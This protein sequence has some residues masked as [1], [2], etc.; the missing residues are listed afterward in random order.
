MKMP[1]KCPEK[2]REA[3]KKA[4]KKYRE[5]NREKI[6][7]V[8]LGRYHKLY[9]NSEETKEYRREYLKKY[10]E[11]NREKIREYFANN[12]S[13]K[14]KARIRASQWQ[15][16]NVGRTRAK[17]SL[18]KKKVKQATP[19]W[20]NR[21]DLGE[22]YEEAYRMELQ[23]GIKHHV[24]H[25]IPLVHPDVCGLHIPSN[26]QVLPALENLKKGNRF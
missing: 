13:I 14:E 23:T 26:L 10:R 24:D 21:R 7:I 3:S 1:Y 9:K 8:A 19:L 15:R 16:D 17:N 2:R 5:K 12:E 11:D 25:I 22:K 6:N 18:R 4:A 20:S